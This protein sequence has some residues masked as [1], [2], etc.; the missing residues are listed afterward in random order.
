MK[1]TKRNVTDKNTYKQCVKLL[2]NIDRIKR[3]LKNNRTI[4]FKNEYLNISIKKVIIFHQYYRMKYI[5][6]P[7]E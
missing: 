1:I 4:D 6:E 3:D 2:K 5:I 7:Y